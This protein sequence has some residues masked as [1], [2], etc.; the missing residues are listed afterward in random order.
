MVNRN[1]DAV[2]ATRVGGDI[3]F[4]N[5]QFREGYARTMRSGRYLRADGRSRRAVPLSVR[6]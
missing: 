2:V 5:G 4:R 3:V 1:D 6:N